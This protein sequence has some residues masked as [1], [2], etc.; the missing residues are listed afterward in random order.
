ME[1]TYVPPSANNM[2]QANQ[3]RNGKEKQNKKRNSF[4]MKLVPISKNQSEYS[5]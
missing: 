5:A 2:Q 3:F 1:I 4:L